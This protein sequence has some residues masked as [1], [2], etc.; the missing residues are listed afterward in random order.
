MQNQKINAMKSCLLFT[1]TKKVAGAEK[2]VAE[3]F[4]GL[5]GSNLNL[6]LATIDSPQLFVALFGRFDLIHSHLFLPGLFIR[7][8]RIF[9]SNF[10]WVHT[11]HYGGYNSQKAA[12]FKKFIDQTFIFPKA[13]HL[14]AVSDSVAKHLDANKKLSCP[15]ST[16]QNCV[17]F[18]SQENQ[19]QPPRKNTN[20]VLGNIVLGTVA[21][22]RPEKGILDIIIALSLL[23]NTEQKFQ[24]KIAGDGPQRKVLEKFIK[25]HGLEN[26]VE[27]CGYVTDIGSFFSSIDI[28]INASHIESFGIAIIEAMQFEVPIVAS[29]VGEVPSVLQNGKFG[30]LV[31]RE[32]ADFARNLSESILKIVGDL[33]G[34][35]RASRQGYLF[36]RN[37]LT[38][39]KFISDHKNLYEKLLKPG[40][41]MISPIVTHSTGGIQK[42]LKLQSRELSRLGYQVFILQ[43]KD[44]YFES[45]KSEW[46]HV[47]FLQTPTLPQSMIDRFKPLIRLNGIIFII[48]GLLQLSRIRRRISLT[49]AHQLFSST[50][51]GFMAK[52]LF[53]KGLVVKV[54]A[55]GVFGELNELKKL[56]FGRLRHFSFRSI[57]RVIVLS[58]E[59]KNEMRELGFSEN[60]ITLIPNSVEISPFLT[61]ISTL[62]KR[63]VRLLFTGRLSQEK[64]LKTLIEAARLLSQ[65][66]IDCEVSLVGGASY[67]GRVVGPVSQINKFYEEADIFILPSISEGMSNALLEAMAHGIPCVV[68]AIPA[69]LFVVTHGHDALTFKTE[70][71]TDLAFQLRRLIPGTTETNILRDQLGKAARL[72]ILTRFTVQSIGSKLSKLYREV[73]QEQNQAQS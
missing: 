72:T 62:L 47:T 32:G 71:S 31:P 60:R 35:R 11:V 33:D 49:H 41:C 30:I 56:P 55:S 58:D 40:I 38:P 16:I 73:E 27:L 25:K 19:P 3:I 10:I 17:H 6:N 23:R 15:I 24:L 37:Q 18:S 7:V 45:K 64:S 12:S 48:F 68:S 8:R 43:K 70:D 9:N 50:T 59:M 13:D 51:V 67:G 61:P 22:L 53:N 69:N 14:I 21:M 52:F 36:H 2:V 65:E 39:E 46:T 54:T 44:P 26:Q 5:S 42:Q 4:K 34:Y 1:R 29:A 63:P 66:G 57:D 20:L 28:F